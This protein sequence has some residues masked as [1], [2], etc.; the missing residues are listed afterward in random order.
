MTHP[1]AVY[2]HWIFCLSKCD[3]NSY[4]GRLGDSVRS[5]EFVCALCLAWPDGRLER[6]RSSADDPFD[7]STLLIPL[8]TR[9]DTKER[10]KSSK[11][12]YPRLNRKGDQVTHPLAVYIHWPSIAM[13]ADGKR[14]KSGANLSLRK[15]ITIEDL[16]SDRFDHVY[17]FWRRNA[18]FNV[19]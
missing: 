6:S 5:A 9:L 15:S 7:R 8:R 1:L 2:I 12:G 10:H 14:V 4:V 18:L 11:S 3:F 17:F 19:R 16:L 13:S